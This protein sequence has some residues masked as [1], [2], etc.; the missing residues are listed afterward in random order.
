MAVCVAEGDGELV[1]WVRKVGGDGEAGEFKSTVLLLAS[2]QVIPRSKGGEPI[3]NQPNQS[4]RSLMLLR[5]QLINNQLLQGLRLRRRSKLA[6]T[7]LVNVAHDIVLDRVESHGSEQVE[8]LGELL[9][10]VEELGRVDCVVLVGVDWDIDEGRL[11]L[12]EER[13]CE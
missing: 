11:H 13:H 12:L 1:G 10:G 2:T 4:L 9:G 6:L 5:L 7:D 8:Q 3:P